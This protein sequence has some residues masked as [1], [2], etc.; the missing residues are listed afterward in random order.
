MLL[1]FNNKKLVFLLGKMQFKSVKSGRNPIVATQITKEWYAKF[2]RI[3]SLKLKLLKP[4]Q[5][6]MKNDKRNTGSGYESQLNLDSILLAHKLS[7]RQQ[8]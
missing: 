4:P 5:L 1:D 3:Q 6:K 7:T 2:S 8:L